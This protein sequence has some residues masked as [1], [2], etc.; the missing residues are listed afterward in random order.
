MR[1]LTVT[2]ALL[3]TPALAA[4]AEDV[5]W[6]SADGETVTR[7]QL[8]AVVAAADIVLLGEVHDRA[9][10]H[11]RQAR[12]IEWASRE[13]NPGIVFEMIGPE[14]A[15]A[16]GAWAERPERTAAEL[17]PAVDWSERGWPDWSLYVPIVEAATA[18]DL[19]LHPGAPAAD[20]VERAVF[21]DGL[22]GEEREALGLDRE[23]PAAARERLLERLERAHGGLGDAV[24]AER[25]LPAQR[26]RDAT[27]AQALIEVQADA[28]AAVLI[29]GREH[30]RRDYG[31]PFYLERLAPELDV[32]SIGLLGRA[33]G[34]AAA[35]PAHP[36]RERFDFAWFPAA[37]ND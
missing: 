15:E 31:V 18:A 4:A 28:G 2:L 14:Q 30:V 11:R 37:A 32:V 35:A 13:R 25:M 12:S 27:M 5:V 19:T 3:L 1:C 8:A 9:E 10:H 17:G 29:A 22:D 21:G 16:L 34:E 33:Q 36:D 23:L 26:L 7:E 6:A 20:R 24:A